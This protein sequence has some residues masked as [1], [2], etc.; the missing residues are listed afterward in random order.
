DRMVCLIDANFRTPGLCTEFEF[1]HSGE[2]PYEEWMFAPVA[3]HG[4][5]R[6]ESNLWLLSYKPS[7]TLSP[8]VA[9]VQGFQMRVSEL[10]QDFAYVLIDAPPLNEYADAASFGQMADGLVM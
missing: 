10:R 6:K 4:D 1:E 5:E 7:F 8:S 2:E 3:R 9:S